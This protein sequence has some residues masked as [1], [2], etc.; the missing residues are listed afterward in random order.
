M[1]NEL[2]LQDLNTLIIEASKTYD[3]VWPISQITDHLFLGQ[4]RTTLYGGMLWKLGITHVLSIGRSPHGSVKNGPFEKCEIPDVPDV[5]QT[6]LS[7]HFIDIFDFVK[8]AID[9]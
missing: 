9:Q 8:K 5:E 3:H 2:F 1:S 6:D 7:K 4:G